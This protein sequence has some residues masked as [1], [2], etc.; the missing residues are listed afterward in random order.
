MRLVLRFIAILSL[1]A[2]ALI[3]LYVALA[4]PTASPVRAL[5]DIV[6]PGDTFNVTVSF[7]SPLDTFFIPV[8]TDY[9]PSGWTVEVKQCQPPPENVL[10]TNAA[11]YSKVEILWKSQNYPRGTPFTACY[12][13]TVPDNASPGDYEFSGD[14]YFHYDPTQP[15][16]G[17]TEATGGDSHI[18][19]SLPEISF[20][21]GSISFTAPQG[22]A[23][24]R[25]RELEI[26]NSGGGTL[27]WTLSCSASWLGV[28]STAG[29]STGEH[30]VIAVSANITGMSGG[31]YSA[32]ISITAPAAGNSP[33]LVPVTLNIGVPG[34]YVVPSNLAFGAV[35]GGL[36]P[37]NQTLLIWNSGGSGTTL[38]W[39]L[40]D[41]A[42]WLDE[43]V[44]SGN[45]TG[46]DDKTPVGVAVNITGKSAGDYSANITIAD[47]LAG[48]S[49]RLV[50]VT[51]HLSSPS[52]PG[53][54]RGDANGDGV[55]DERDLTILKGIILGLGADSGSADCNKDGVVNALDITA[56]KRVVLGLG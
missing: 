22:G 30:D 20:S 51:L 53:T 50:P 6:Q 10:A 32:T 18:Y 28:D 2:I 14:L 44:T 55:V 24:P 48:N 56:I 43:N 12:A 35:Q 49:P 7:T 41:D 8:V 40:S 3:P 33:R 16:V 31:G 13:V 15:F 1:T 36:T 34:I 54:G 5:P 42:A 26:W 39:T 29:S 52:S 9:A 11:T 23:N 4:Q 38:S 37:G 27:N 17:F 19:V 46:K 21:P 45:S 47:P 25:D